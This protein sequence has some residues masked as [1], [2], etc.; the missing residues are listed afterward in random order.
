MYCNNHNWRNYW[1]DY[2][3]DDYPNNTAN[4]G[5]YYTDDYQNKT[6][7]YE[8]DYSDD[9]KRNVKADHEAYHPD[10]KDHRPDR[11]AI[12]TH[13][14]EF[15]GSV[16]IEGGIPHNHRFAGVTSEAI[17]Y[18]NSHVHSICVNTDFFFNHYHEIGVTTGPAIKVPGG[19][20]IH[21]VDGNT[22]L[23]FGHDHD[24]EF[25]TAIEDPLQI[26]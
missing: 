25:T 12:Q 9:T 16:T 19:K 17:P 4:W 13:N 10:K 1:E 15:S 26:K 21:Y 7:N 5:N 2:Y 14:H 6:A 22:T 23:N 18:K 20:H 8:T 11:P 3:P 24:F